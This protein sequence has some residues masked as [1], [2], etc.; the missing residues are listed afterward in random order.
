MLTISSIRI[1]GNLV[2]A[3]ILLFASFVYYECSDPTQFEFLDENDPRTW[4]VV[5]PEVVK[6]RTIT[7]EFSPRRTRRFPFLKALVKQIVTPERRDLLLDA[8]SNINNNADRGPYLRNPKVE[9][10]ENH[11]RLPIESVAHDVI[12]EQEDN[13][14][15][16][17]EK[18]GPTRNRRFFLINVLS[19]MLRSVN[20]TAVCT[21]Y[22]HRLTILSRF[23]CVF[24]IIIIFRMT[25]FWQTLVRVTSGAPSCIRHPPPPVHPSLR[26]NLHNRMY[27]ALP[28]ER[29]S[30]NE[31]R[32]ALPSC[33]LDNED[34]SDCFP[35]HEMLRNWITGDGFELT[36]WRMTRGCRISLN[37]PD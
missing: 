37:Y 11:V 5:G 34:S 2:P 9:F 26:L 6:E 7:L 17:I 13:N 24:I 3:L 28:V 36:F 14:H 33:T 4:G 25:L 30:F 1:S 12:A 23:S 22:S 32:S 16:E 8:Q 31:F 18:P 27:S 10:K 21:N 19:R 35:T 20:F 15:L 29:R